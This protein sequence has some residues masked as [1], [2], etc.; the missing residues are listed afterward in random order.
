MTTRTRL[1]DGWVSILRSVTPCCAA[2]CSIWQL[3]TSRW[4]PRWAGQE[5][6]RAPPVIA[7]PGPVG[8]LRV[9]L[10]DLIGRAGDAATCSRRLTLPGWSR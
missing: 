1:E 8:N 5:P 4:L 2:T 7:P 10:T 6:S 9:E 3:S